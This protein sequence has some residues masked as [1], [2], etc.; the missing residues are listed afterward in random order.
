MRKII[1]VII[2][3]LSLILV[4]GC[5]GEQVYNA[6]LSAYSSGKSSLDS[7][8]DQ[9]CQQYCQKPSPN[10]LLNCVCSTPTPTPI[11]SFT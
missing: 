10:N 2:I 6:G 4:M 1:I 3:L 11:P 7:V 5:I 9:Q 8:H